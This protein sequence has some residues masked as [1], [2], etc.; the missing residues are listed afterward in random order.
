MTTSEE[1]QAAFKYLW[2][3]EVAALKTLAQSLPANPIVVNL[4]AGAGTS[5]LA[6]MESR[7]DLELVT[8]DIQKDDSPLGCLVAEE[9]ALKS[10]GLWNP[11]RVHHIHNESIT[12]GKQW[13]QMRKDVDAKPFLLF[14]ANPPL[15]D[16]VW[17]DGDHSYEGARGDI[18]AWL[19]NIKPGGILAIHDYHKDELYKNATDY[20][21]DAPHPQDWPGVTKAVDELLVGRYEMVMRVSSLVAFRVE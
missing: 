12:V 11:H 13:Q 10:A 7:G 19:P 3:D 5:G 8:I 21:P 4:G 2:A 20:K 17:I 15:V 14:I 1:L 9:N 6:F 16:L 18:E